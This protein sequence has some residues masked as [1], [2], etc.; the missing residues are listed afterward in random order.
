MKFLKSWI[1]WRA[2]VLAL[3]LAV[4][5]ALPFMSSAPLRRDYYFFDVTL[6]STSEGITQVFWDLGRNKRIK[7]KNANIFLINF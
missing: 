6:T 4:A 5:A 2:I 1:D 3:V 7:N